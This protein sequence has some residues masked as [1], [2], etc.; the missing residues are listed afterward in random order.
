MLKHLGDCKSNIK[1]I[2]QI[3][4]LSKTKNIKKE[5]FLIE[6]LKLDSA[7]ASA[8]LPMTEFIIFLQI[9]ALRFVTEYVCCATNSRTKTI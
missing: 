4:M 7:S 1:K 2:K 6:L 3:D 5:A 9:N 8:P